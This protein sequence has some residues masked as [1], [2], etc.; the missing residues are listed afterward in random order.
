MSSNPDFQQLIGILS[1]RRR[2]ILSVTALGMLAAGL[3]AMLLPAR[4]TAKVQLVF[5]PQQTSRVGDA[6]TLF[7][8]TGEDALLQTQ[9]ATLLSFG[10]RERIRTSLPDDQAYRTVFEQAN[11]RPG[12]VDVPH[13]IQETWSGA[14]EWLPAWAS[15]SPSAPEP[16][17]TEPER[18]VVRPP[19]PDEFERNLRVF[20][21]MNSHVIAATYTART[22]EL[23]MVI[24]NRIAA[25][26]IQAETEQKRVASSLE[27]AW[28]ETRIPTLRSEVDGAEI[29]IRDYATTHGYA[30][31]GSSPTADQE[32]VELNRQVFAAELD[33]ASRQSRLSYVRN[34]LRGSGPV[35]VDGL[36]SA[37]L[38]DLQRQETALLQSAADLATTVGDLNPHLQGVRNQLQQIRGR[39]AQEKE[40]ASTRSGRRGR[41]CGLTGGSAPHTARCH[42]RSPL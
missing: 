12:R 5:E 37:V 24:A 19:D 31:L 39:I 10:T 42:Q 16:R 33:L 38:N 35:A 6:P 9:V 36:N 26:H 2:M 3:G 27:L 22:P 15:P 23:A 21:E 1:R 18:G 11:S 41:H 30:S 29:A 32:A 25:S 40:L 20:Q 7:N 17:A 8:P 13:W 4:Y 14:A 34:R 28:L